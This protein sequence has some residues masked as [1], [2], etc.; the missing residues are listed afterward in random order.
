LLRTASARP[1]ITHYDHATGSRVELSVATLANWAAKTANWL[2]EE[3]DIEPG[4]K[5]AVHL[6]AHWQTAGILLGAWWCGAHVVE[7]VEDARIVF[8][9]PEEKIQTQTTTAI[10]SLNPMGLGLSEVPSGNAVDFLTE[11]RIAGD[12]F[13]S[14][15]PIPGNTPAL[16]SLSVD[17]LLVAARDSAALHKISSSDRVLS[18]MDWTLPSGVIQTLLATIA[19]GAHLVQIS[20][21]DKEK[22][23][24]CRQSERTT[25]ELID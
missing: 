22:L 10:V 12:D 18:T 13:Q 8:V 1:L 25:V 5:V 15:Q 4:D 7:E 17:E 6:P 2:T 16:L 20:N 9:G 19:A 21:P 24:N 23:I 14:Y 3:V 11:V